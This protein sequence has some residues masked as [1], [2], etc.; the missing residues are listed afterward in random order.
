MAISSFFFFFGESTQTNTGIHIIHSTCEF[1]CGKRVASAF[2]AMPD[3]ILYIHTCGPRMLRWSCQTR[4]FRFCTVTMKYESTRRVVAADISS[5]TVL[6]LL[7]SPFLA[8]IAPFIPLL[9]NKCHGQTPVLAITAKTC[10]S[11]LG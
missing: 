4:P 8:V 7:P 1:V 11:K 6:S 5:C 9:D 2:Q 3:Y 10:R